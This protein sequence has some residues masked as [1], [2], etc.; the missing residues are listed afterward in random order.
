[1]MIEKFICSQVHLNKNCYFR[2]FGKSS[3]NKKFKEKN[4]MTIENMTRSV[5]KFIKPID[6]FN[7][8]ITY[9]F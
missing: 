3:L 6:F 1:M 4:Q 8:M 2:R 5:D 7:H 9:A